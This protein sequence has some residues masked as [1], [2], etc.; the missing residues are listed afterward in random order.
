MKKLIYMLFVGMLATLTSC[1]KD[2]VPVLGAVE[3]SDITASTINC[4]CEVT[5]GSIDACGFYY[6]TSKS[7]VSTK[8]ADKME[9]TFDGTAIVAQLSKL[10]P[11]K[12]YYIMAYG[13]NEL[14]EG[15]SAILSIKTDH[16]MPGSGDMPYPEY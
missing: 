15:T 5:E 11:N 6:S 16:R 9:G 12:M 3:T 4:R 1:E 8:K 2:V 14:G 10:Q 13:M 7:R